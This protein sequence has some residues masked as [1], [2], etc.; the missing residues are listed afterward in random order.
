[1]KAFAAAEALRG[2]ATSGDE[3]VG[4][5]NVGGFGA[6]D[7]THM[8]WAAAAVRDLRAPDGTVSPGA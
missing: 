2:C 3:L 7:V 4:A 1:M 6:W 8:V 5:L